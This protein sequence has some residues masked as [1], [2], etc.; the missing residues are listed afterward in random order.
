MCY[1][2]CEIDTDHVAFLITTRAHSAPAHLC[3]LHLEILFL[4][5]FFSSLLPILPPSLSLWPSPLRTHM[6]LHSTVCDCRKYIWNVLERCWNILERWHVKGQAIMLVDFNVPMRFAIIIFS[7]YFALLLVGRW[8]KCG[9]NRSDLLFLSFLLA[10]VIFSSFKCEIDNSNT[11]G[12]TS[13]SSC[14]V[15]ATT[16][17][18]CCRVSESSR[19]KLQIQINFVVRV[20]D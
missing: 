10:C 20:R 18:E 5:L 8:V 17:T 3:Y 11:M 7:C 13:S 2:T 1:H 9:Y 4:C 6:S 15:S 16:T 14:I 12:W 19:I